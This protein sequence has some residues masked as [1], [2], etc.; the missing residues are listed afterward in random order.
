VLRISG[1]ISPP[2]RGR[3]C[4][5]GVAGGDVFST[6]GKVK[7]TGL[8]QRRFLIAAVVSFFASS[9]PDGLEFVA[10]SLGFLEAAG[11]SPTAGSPLAD[12]AVHGAPP[13]LATGLAG[14]IG[15]VVVLGVAS[16]VGVVL[17]RRRR[18]TP[19]ARPEA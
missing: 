14:V 1:E 18:V 7:G 3:D 6:A 15:V 5:N 8:L 12:Y 10:G 11:D 2:G 17:R 16:L 4:E 9:S 13:V 19:S